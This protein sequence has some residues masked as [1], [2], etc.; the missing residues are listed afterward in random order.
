MNLAVVGGFYQER[1]AEPYWDEIYGS[2]GRAAAAITNRKAAV[3]LVTYCPSSNEKK[4]QYFASTFGFTAI[5]TPSPQTVNFQYLHWLRKPDITPARSFFHDLPPLKVIDYDAVLRFGLFEGHAIVRAKRVVYDPQDGMASKPFDD[6]GSKADELVIVCNY[7]EGY[8]LTG[9]RDPEKIISRLFTVSNVKA[10]VLKGAW[11]GSI[12]AA[13]SAR[14]SIRPIP[15]RHVR[16]IGSGDI[17][18]AEFTYHWAIAG[19]DPIQAAREANNRVAYYCENGVLPIPAA[20]LIAPAKTPTLANSGKKFDMYLAAPFF[21][22]GQLAVV[23]EIRELL[24][25]SGV[26]IFSPYHNVG[27]GNATKVAAQDVAGIQ[28]SRLVFACLDGYDP[29][30]VFEVGYA[31]ALNIPVLIYSP[32]LTDTNSTMFI[33]TGCE[34]VRDFTSAIYRAAWWIKGK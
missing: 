1:C 24:S 29:G 7:T 13:G 26:S 21:N 17:F 18:S 31:R 19:C 15:T 2:G 27:F 28:E 14:E 22:A 16:K 12:V 32:N 34:I 20:V 5:S 10:V 6:N 3:T 8:R 25:Q 23:E 33:G 30:T 9:E 4:L 11:E